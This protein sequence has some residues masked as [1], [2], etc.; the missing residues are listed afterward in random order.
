MEV[1]KHSRIF[2]RDSY[3]TRARDEDDVWRLSDLFDGCILVLF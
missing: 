1:D 3:L 2:V